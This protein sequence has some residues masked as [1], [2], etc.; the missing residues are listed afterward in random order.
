METIELKAYARNEFGKGSARRLRKQGLIPAVFYGAT[1]KSIPLTVNSSEL[2]KLLGAVKGES[3][4]IKLTIED[5]GDKVEKLSIIKDLQVN[6]ISR[7]HI[8]TDF[9]EIRMDHKITMDIPIRLTGQAIGIEEGGDLQ[10]AKRNLK[11]SALPS[12]IPDFIEVDISNLNIGDAVK[13]ENIV[14]GE[15]IEVLDPADVTI[16]AVAITRVTVEVEEGKPE[17]ELPEKVGE[18]AESEEEQ[19]KEPT[20]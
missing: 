18:D 10:F 9:Y 15:D 4:F 5:D 13:V 2:V 6:P 17:G 19:S 8:H 12:S 1:V 20:E 7:N 14:L 11:V 3:K 16:A